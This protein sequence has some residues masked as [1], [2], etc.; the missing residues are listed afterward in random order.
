MTRLVIFAKAPQPGTAKTRLIPALGAE[1]A[2]ELA[3]RMLHHTLAQA[4]GVGAQSV[5]LCMSPP[6]CAPTWQGVTLPTGIE[7]TAQCD[8]DLGARMSDALERALTQQHGP[9][10]LMGTD[11]PALTAERIE[12]ASQQLAHHDA[13]LLPAVDGGYVL[14]GLHNAC[15]A[16]FTDMAW[17]TPVVAQETLRRMASA[18]LRVWQGPRLHDIDEPAD[19]AHLPDDLRPAGHPTH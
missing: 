13:V 18:G 8:G 6:P 14:M 5:E 4:L 11:C 2:A 19:L 10:L 7:C 15:P 12:E 16:L 17:S 3:R 9:V 1:G